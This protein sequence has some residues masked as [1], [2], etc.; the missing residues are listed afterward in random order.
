MRLIIISAVTV[1]ATLLTVLVVVGLL[2]SNGSRRIQV[3]GVDPS[4]TEGVEAGSLG[5]N[6]PAEGAEADRYPGFSFCIEAIGVNPAV[7]AVAKTRVETAMVQ[8]MQHPLWN[9]FHSDWA[10]PL[11]NVGCP[12]D[13]LVGR[14][15]I[16]TGQGQY[17]GGDWIQYVVAEPSFYRTFVFIMP[18]EEIDRLLGGLT[19]RVAPQEFVQTGGDVF[20][21]QTNAIF[22]SPEE[23]EDPSFLVQWLTYA[24]GLEAQY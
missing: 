6:Q 13:P 10:P 24:T 9:L 3:D 17:V 11:M 12:S 15:G 2:P 19:V 18:L 1:V 23:L 7:E 4:Q 21:E 8:V 14:P 5:T 22:V 16:E 20:A